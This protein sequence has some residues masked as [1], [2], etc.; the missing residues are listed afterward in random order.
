MDI[1]SMHQKDYMN[2]PVTCTIY[3]RKQQSFQMT[4]C[5]RR[6]QSSDDNMLQ[7][8]A[9]YGLRHGIWTTTCCKKQQ[10]FD[11]INLQED[12]RMCMAVYSMRQQNLDDIKLQED[13]RI[14][15]TACCK[16]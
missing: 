5:C 10:S 15:M 7:E 4:A 6:Q 3:L 1:S 13:S 12:R 14:E 16:R 9:E 11:D 8:K 2:R